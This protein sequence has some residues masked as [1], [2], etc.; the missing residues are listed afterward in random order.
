MQNK[1]LIIPV[2]L[3]VAVLMWAAGG[4]TTPAVVASVDLEKVYSSLDQQK[5]S[6]GKVVVLRGE[7][8]KRITKLEDEVRAMKDDLES[9]QTGSTAH[10]EALKKVILRASDLTALHKFTQVKVESEQA[11]TVREAYMA[12]RASCAKI[13]TEQ[14]VDFVFIDDTVPTINPTNLEG[15][16]QQIT[17]RRMLY[18]NPAL[19]ITDLL[20]ERMNSD[21]RA[22]N[23]STGSPQTL[24]P[25]LPGKS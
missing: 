10:N 11:N 13:A 4:P 5:A 6:N 23:P 7:L 24:T 16:V 14:K 17:G 25:A 2:S 9:F 3:V 21:F 19:D 22:A 15:T 12:I 20:I 8:K 1:Y 18:A